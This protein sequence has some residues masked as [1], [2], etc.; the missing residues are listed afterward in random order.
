MKSAAPN[1]PM[2]I[3]AEKAL[4]AIHVCCFGRDLI[5]KEDER[6]L[7]TILSGVFPSVENREMERIVKDK[8]RRVAD[9]TDEVKIPEAKPLPKE[10]ADMQ[11]KDLE[12][13]KKGGDFKW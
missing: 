6:L 2:E 7:V 3:R 13:L 11:M 9:G 5:E 8:A 12:F 10:A 4:E 1:I